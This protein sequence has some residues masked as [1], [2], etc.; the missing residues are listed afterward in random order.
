MTLLNVIAGCFDVS[1]KTNNGK[2]DTCRSPRRK[3][4][5]LDQDQTSKDGDAI[6]AE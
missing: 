2:T 1:A 5:D 6:V 3:F 4:E